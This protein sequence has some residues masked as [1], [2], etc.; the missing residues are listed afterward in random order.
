LGGKLGK[1]TNKGLVNPPSLAPLASAKSKSA[2][3]KKK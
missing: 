2:G 1:N 3:E